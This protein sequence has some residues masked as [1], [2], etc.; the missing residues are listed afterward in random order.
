[1]PRPKSIDYSG[2]TMQTCTGP[3][4]PSIAAQSTRL[5]TTNQG[6]TLTASATGCGTLSYQWYR[7]LSG[8]V[9]TPLGTSAIYTTGAL[10]STTNFWV[11]ATDSSTNTSANSATMVITVCDPAV[12]TIQPQG[13]SPG[14][15]LPSSNQ[16]TTLT[17]A[18]SGCA[19]LSYQWYRGN[20][21]DTS[22][23]Q[24]GT[25]SS[26]STGP[27]TST[28]SFWV[29]VTDST[30]PT[31]TNSNTA[32]VRVATQAPPVPTA[33]N[34][35]VSSVVNQTYQI[36]VTWQGSGASY[37]IH[38]CSISGC[39]TFDAASPYVDVNV[40][41]N[42][43]YAYAVQAIDSSGNG[44]SAFSG[45]DLATT[46]VFSTLQP[47]VT[48]VSLAHLTELLNGLNAVRAVTGQAW[49]TWQD[50]HNRYISAHPTEIFP[51][52]AANSPI[53]AVHIKA[54][55]AEMDFARGII[56]IAALPYTDSLTTPTVI[57]AIHFTELQSRT[58]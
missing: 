12:I 32:I 35:H 58:Q 29:Q 15:D 52:P 14:N 27:L 55:R 1:M 57:K 43:T 19:L 8:D 9:S 30:G 41:A 22:S 13:T 47:G 37:R 18:A 50:V 26:F 11:K 7:G 6:T 24:Q 38:R 10:P 17:V 51:L 45:Y 44:V 28:T 33:V 39:S 5:G 23:A 49:L 2:W 48:V 4:T 34:A 3:S 42:T 21:G 40:V 36:T 46:M 31:Q 20:T 25:T 16:G 53:F 56:G 54:L